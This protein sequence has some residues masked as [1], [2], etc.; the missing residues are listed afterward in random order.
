MSAEDGKT[1]GIVKAHRLGLDRQGSY[2][3]PMCSCGW[4]GD[5]RRLNNSTRATLDGSHHVCQ[6]HALCTLRSPTIFDWTKVRAGCFCGWEGEWHE[7]SEPF[8]EDR[9]H[10]E[11]QEHRRLIL[12][13]AWG[14]QSGRA[15]LTPA[16]VDAIHEAELRSYGLRPQSDRTP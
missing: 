16:E 4:R 12:Q 11:A 1:G 2:V 9:T 3:R 8:V 10:D 6:D 14:S 13:S 15:E 7:R 5:R